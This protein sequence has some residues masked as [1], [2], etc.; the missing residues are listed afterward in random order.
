[1]TTFAVLFVLGVIGC[2]GG[3]T[4]AAGRAAHTRDPSDI[5]RIVEESERARA[6]ETDMEDRTL[7][8]VTD[9]VPHRNRTFRGEQIYRCFAVYR[10]NDYGDRVTSILCVAVVDAR[11]MT[12][13]VG[14][15]SCFT[16]R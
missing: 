14:V 6:P 1:M 13:R 8:D 4:T 3:T 5:A 16:P 15:P 2:G 10:D 9:C 11:A 7:L 12:Q